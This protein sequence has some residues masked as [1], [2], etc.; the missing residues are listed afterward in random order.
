MVAVLQPRAKLGSDQ[1]HPRS[2]PSTPASAILSA[3]LF[4]RGIYFP[5]MGKRAWLKLLFDNRKP[6][7]S[8]TREGIQT[9]RKFRK[10]QRLVAQNGTVALD[11][12][13]DTQ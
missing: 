11:S 9:W 4:F 13:S 5:Q 6:I 2:A 3:R 7:L 1:L 10:K 8:L 12:V